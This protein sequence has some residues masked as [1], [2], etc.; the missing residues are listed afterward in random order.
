MTNEEL[1]DM[2]ELSHFDTEKQSIFEMINMEKIGKYEVKDGVFYIKIASD[3]YYTENENIQSD[4]KEVI[5]QKI[6]MFGLD[7]ENDLEEIIIK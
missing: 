3:E 5:E 2:W 6:I 4:I 7:Y 1:K